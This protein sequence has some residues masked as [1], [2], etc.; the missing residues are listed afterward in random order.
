MLRKIELC[1]KYLPDFEAV[2][3]IWSVNEEHFQLFSHLAKFGGSDPFEFPDEILSP[4][5]AETSL[6]PESVGTIDGQLQ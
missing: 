1:E 2:L 3:D 5:P 4:L 6:L